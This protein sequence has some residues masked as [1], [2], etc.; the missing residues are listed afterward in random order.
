MNVRL[1]DFV[2]TEIGFFAVN[3]Y[4]HPKDR[5]FAFLRYLNLNAVDNAMEIINKY[6]LNR[7]DI[8]N[9]Q[10]I[11]ITDTSKTHDILKDNFPEYL[12][13]DKTK[14]ITLHAIPKSKIIKIRTPQNRLKEIINNPTNEFEIKCKKIAEILNKNGLDYGCMGVSGSTVIKLNNIN[15]DI[16]FVI[17]GMENHKKARGILKSIFDEKLNKYCANNDKDNNSG[18]RSSSG[19]SSIKYNIKP[20]SDEFWKKAYNKRIKDGTLSYEE[21]VWHEKR[22]YNRGAINGTMFDL[23]ATREWNEINI[24]YGDYIYKNMGFIEIEGTITND[25]YMLDNPAIYNIENVKIT[26]LELN[27]KINKKINPNS[28]KEI[29]SFTHTYAGQAFEGETV[30]VRGKLETVSSKNENYN[31]IVVGTSREALNEYIKLL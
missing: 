25:K 27:K 19:S 21:F 20:L 5:I 4:E 31:R 3:T 30:V 14:D 11:K 7:Q 2:E 18:S 6:D 8:R 9:N 23:L 24:N 29:A 28:I 1:R 13:H 22:K 10:Y 26:N 12:F 17:Y 16:D 15:S